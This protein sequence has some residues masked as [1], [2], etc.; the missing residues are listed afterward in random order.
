MYRFIRE[1]KSRTEIGQLVATGGVA[2]LA[3]E[4]FFKFGSFSLECLAFLG[5]WAVLDM[6]VSVCFGDTRPA[7][8]TGEGKTIPAPRS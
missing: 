6:V 8:G 5:T 1:S 2:L 4:A 3:A 7:A